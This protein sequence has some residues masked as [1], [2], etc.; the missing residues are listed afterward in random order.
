MSQKLSTMEEKL[1]QIL[2][3]SLLA[4]KNVLTI[5]DTSLL[6]GL[7]KSTLYSMT[8]KRQIP[9]YKRA[10]MIYFDRSE[11]EAWMKQNRIATQQETERN[12]IAYVVTG[13]QKGGA[14]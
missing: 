1:D 9:Y 8:C 4:A 2:A 10:K 14:Q 3:Y 13:K 5:E 7:S 11:I 12:A 6:T